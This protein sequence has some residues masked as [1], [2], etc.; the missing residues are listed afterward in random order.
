MALLSRSLKGVFCGWSLLSVLTPRCVSSLP[1]G[2]AERGPDGG[3]E[4]HDPSQLPLHLPPAGPA[5]GG[6]SRGPLQQHSAE[7]ADQQRAHCVSRG[8]GS[9]GGVAGWGW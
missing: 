9:V 7:A 5:A 6:R 4:L 3:G 2:G 8:G 1:P